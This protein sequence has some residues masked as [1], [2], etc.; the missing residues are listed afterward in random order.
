MT[1]RTK[2][3][4]YVVAALCTG[5]I[6]AF[7]FLQKLRLSPEAG[8]SV[9]DWTVFVIFMVVIG[10]IG[11]LEGPLIGVVIFFLLRE[12]FSRFWTE[13]YLIP[14]GVIFTL[15]VIFLP[16]GI[17]GFARRRLNS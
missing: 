5:M 3:L 14:V 7:I 16:Q 15:M 10:G 6:G 13:Y 4:I 2:L 11:T 12:G 8:F 17:L 9:N 1:F